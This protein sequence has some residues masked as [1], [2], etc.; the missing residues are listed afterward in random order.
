MIG[1]A[2]ATCLPQT[3]EQGAVRDGG[4]QAFDGTEGGA[5]FEGVPGEERLAASELHGACSYS[6]NTD[7]NTTIIHRSRSPRQDRC[8]RKI[9]KNSSAKALGDKKRTLAGGRPFSFQ[10][11]GPEITRAHDTPTAAAF[12]TMHCPSR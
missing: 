3:V 7:S 10:Y 2:V 4:Q 11:P 6:Y 5:V 1:P 8:G 12:L 9:Q